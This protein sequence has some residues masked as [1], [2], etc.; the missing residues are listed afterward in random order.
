MN[1]NLQNQNNMNNERLF[2]DVFRFE[3]NSRIA[4]SF[5][6]NL[7]FLY[8]SDSKIIKSWK[9]EIT[10]ASVDLLITES[11]LGTQKG[12]TR[13]DFLYEVF[14]N[15][16]FEMHQRITR[17]SHELRRLNLEEIE[18]LNEYLN[19]HDTTIKNVIYLMKG[20]NSRGEQTIPLSAE[21]FGAFTSE[22]RNLIVRTPFALHFNE[23]SD[24]PKNTLRNSW[25]VDF[26]NSERR[27]Y[28]DEIEGEDF[29]NNLLQPQ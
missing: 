21:L 26:R 6:G 11:H 19:S 27:S 5:S 3:K 24:N 4:A 25:D 13:W 8:N 23:N 1:N 18:R 14:L 22:R 15:D 10:E 2:Y 17:G 20:S 7:H 12:N 16:N 9:W 29:E 28:L